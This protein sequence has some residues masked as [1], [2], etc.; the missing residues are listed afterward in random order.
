MRTFVLASLLAAAL[1]GP[2]VAS[3]QQVFLR[4]PE[5]ITLS[6]VMLRRD[7]WA[8]VTFVDAYPETSTCGTVTYGSVAYQRVVW[9]EMAANA[10]KQLYATM[11][12]AL[13]TGKKLEGAV[14]TTGGDCDLYS[15]RLAQ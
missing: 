15:V 4:P 7:G 12:T 11:L 8:F 5:G 3:A 1:L 14:I 10:G 6:N 13:V 9:I 2:S